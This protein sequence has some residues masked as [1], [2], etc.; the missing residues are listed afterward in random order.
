MIQNK[1]TFPRGYRMFHKEQ[2]FNYQLNR[3]YSLG[4]AR[5]EDIEEAGRKINNFGDWKREM[6]RLAEEAETEGRL[7][8]AAFYYRAAE[9]YTF[10]DDPDKEGLY[11]KFISL[12]YRIFIDEGIERFKIPYEKAFLPAL[13]VPAAGGVKKGVIV[14]HGGFDSFIEEFY[15]WMRYFSDKG[16]EVIAFE[17]QGQGG[18]R[19]KYSLLLDYRWEKPVKAVLDY[20]ELEEATLL[21]ISMGGWL[22]FRAAAF[23]ARIK[24]VIAVGI[25]YDY[26]KF[27]P[28]WA[29]LLMNF[30]FNHLRGFTNKMTFKKMAKEGMHKWSLGN[31]MYISDTKTPLDAV[32]VIKEMNSKNLHSEMVEQDVLILTGRND[33][34]I[35]F[36]MHRMQVKALS[37]AKSVTGRIFNREEEAHNHC[38]IGNQGLALEVMVKW[39]EEVS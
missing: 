10:Q 35:P 15:S 6:M 24:R 26:L 21:G 36:K 34:F 32:D 25:A 18:A 7:L 16:Y 17:G 1:F 29:R 37:K 4:Y 8:N 39:L 19:R 20:F 38:Q 31:L 11:D 14:M 2:L 3:W 5:W 28:L 13:R 9:F 27:P 22:C 23:E 30:F 12:F 33:H